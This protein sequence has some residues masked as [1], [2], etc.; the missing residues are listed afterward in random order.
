MDWD[1]FC[2]EM[3]QKGEFMPVYIANPNPKIRMHS[4]APIISQ[5]ACSQSTASN[6]FHLGQQDLNSIPKDH[7]IPK[8]SVC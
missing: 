4:K 7:V 2:T 1:N 3:D 6:G 8:C 5:V